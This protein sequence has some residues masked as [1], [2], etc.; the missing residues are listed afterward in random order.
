[1]ALQGL[2]GINSPVTMLHGSTVLRTHPAQDFKWAVALQ[3]RLNLHVQYVAHDSTLH[4]C[5]N[6]KH[7]ESVTHDSKN[8]V[9]LSCGLTA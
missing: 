6:H 7:S 1:M 9:I 4:V 3:M 5:G 8:M 2:G